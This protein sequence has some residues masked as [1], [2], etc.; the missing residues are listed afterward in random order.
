MAG[1]R[2]LNAMPWDGPVE[3]ASVRRA[4][5]EDA[6]SAIAMIRESITRL[7]VADHENDP[8]TLEAWLRNKT[9]DNFARWL[10]GSDNYVVVAEL[11]SEIGGVASLRASGEVQLFYVAPSRQRVGIGTALLVA[12]ES[13]ARAWGLDRL[14]LNSTVGARAFYER[15]GYAPS[16]RPVPGVG[17]SFCFPY[18]KVIL[19]LPR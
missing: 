5:R 3:G 15:N 10:A 6:E 4:M 16:G 12:L 19:S 11:D 9:A 13:Q 2:P 8:V 17:R 14:A 18:E 1:S 7:C